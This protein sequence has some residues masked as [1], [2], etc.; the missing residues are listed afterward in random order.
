MP[1]KKLATDQQLIARY[2]KLKAVFDSLNKQINSLHKEA[3]KLKA[4][5]RKEIDQ[6]E[7]AAIL[8]KI[9]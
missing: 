2:K 1:T 8:K 9:K 6:A 7:A 3:T 5:L 4:K